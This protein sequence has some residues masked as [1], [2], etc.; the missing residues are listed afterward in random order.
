MKILFLGDPHVLV[1]NLEESEHL[2]NFVNESAEIN[3]VDTVIIPGDLFHNFSILRVEVVNFWRRWLEKL[4]MD[5]K[6]NVLMGNHDKKNQSNDDDLENALQ[7]FNL[8]DSP[9]LNIIQSP[10]IIGPFGYVPYIH[11]KDRFVKAANEL[12]VQGAKTL[13]VHGELTGGKFETGMYVP[14]GANPDDIHCD[15]IISGHFHSRQRFGKVIYPGTARWLTSSDKNEP[16]GLWLA[17]FDDNETVLKEEFLDTSHVCTP[18][19]AYQY[20]EGGEE[21]SIPSNSRASVELIGSSEWIS[22]Q[23][24]KFKGIASISCKITDKSKPSNRKTG[25]SFEHFVTNVFETTEGLKKVS[26]IA[27]MRELGILKETE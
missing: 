20:I 22:K 11:D 4:S 3:G 21:I 24:A 15:L 13:F 6:V 27:F 16:K 23:K 17:E 14:N 2:L 10:V 18:I 25:N 5:R 7:I 26:M 9:N 8:I 1:S 12:C 19:Y